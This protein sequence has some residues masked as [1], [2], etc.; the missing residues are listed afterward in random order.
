MFTSDCNIQ[1][2]QKRPLFIRGAFRPEDAVLGPSELLGLACDDQVASR[3]VEREADGQWSLLHGPFDESDFVPRPGDTR[4]WTVLVSEVD[5]HV[6]SRHTPHA[7]TS[8]S[9][10]TLPHLLHRSLR[11]QTSCRVLHSCQTGGWTTCKSFQ[12]LRL[13]FVR[14]KPISPS[15]RPQ[16]NIVRAEGR[17]HRGPRR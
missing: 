6:V 3:M 1:F 2:W 12:R 11:C 17:R 9:P 13:L 7:F 10:T 16:P 8:S 4:R 14:H 15:S 5:R